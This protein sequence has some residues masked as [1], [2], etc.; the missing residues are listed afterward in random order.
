[1][2]KAIFLNANLT[3]NIKINILCSVKYK[4]KFVF[5]SDQR[6]VLKGQTLPITFQYSHLTGLLNLITFI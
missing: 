4:L 5:Y 1:M 2:S 6:H 3:I